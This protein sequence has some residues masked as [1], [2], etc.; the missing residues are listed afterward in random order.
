[1][2]PKKYPYSFDPTYG[3]TLET[4]LDITPPAE[5]EGFAEFWQRAY[6]EAKNAQPMARLADS[7]K[8]ENGWRIY[9]L[10]Y[11]STGGMKIGGWVG[12]PVKG[13]IRRGFVIG[14]GYGGRGSCDTHYP[15]RES[16][17]FYP[18]MRGQWS[19]SLNPPISHEAQ[20]HVLHDI[21]KPEKYVLR[22]CVQDIWVAVTAMLNLFPQVEGHV[23][24]LGGSFGGGLGALALPWDD[25][26]SKAHLGVPTF[27][28]HP[29]RLQCV[30][31]GSGESVRKFHQKHPWVAERTLPYY[32]AAIAATHIK[33]PVHC[34]CALFDPNVCPPGQ[35]AVYNAI[36]GKKKKLYVQDAGH[37]PYDNEAQQS[38]EIMDAI[39]AFFKDL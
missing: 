18:C 27:G 9:D 6:E 29:I 10:Y 23:G 5:P 12:V 31:Q 8:T 19:R 15:L 37:F 11:T 22:G 36:P 33:I 7:G 26:I 17:I 32:D 2:V 21:D 20:Y 4:L 16:V 1:M 24:Y 3:Y 35:F 14:H 30:G 13:P 34:A 38:Q 28:H 25:R 39:E